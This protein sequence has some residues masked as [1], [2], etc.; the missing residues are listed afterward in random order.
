MVRWPDAA[1]ARRNADVASGVIEAWDPL[2]VSEFE[3]R[4]RARLAASAFDCVAG[5]LP[6]DGGGIAV[7]GG[8]ARVLTG[9][10]RR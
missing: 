8:G 2:H 9:M 3:P 1:S 10:G 6:G 4:A 5:R 7:A